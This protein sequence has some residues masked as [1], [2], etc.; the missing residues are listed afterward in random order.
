MGF[1][2]LKSLTSQNNEDTG[3]NM[4]ELVDLQDIINLDKNEINSKMDY[5]VETLV[6][7]FGDKLA[8]KGGYMLT[9]LMPNT[10]R[11][12][13][14]IDFSIGDSKLYH[15]LLKTMETIGNHFVDEGYISSYKIKDE[16][17]EFMSGGMDMYSS[18]G[19]KILGIDIG[20]HDISFGVTTT[21]ID[22]CELSAFM[23]ER[24][25]ADKITAILSRKRFRRPKDIYDLYCI[26]NCFDFNTS[27]INEF[28]LK[29]TQG[30][31]ADWNNFPFKE[32]IIVE[33]KKAYDKLI[34]TSMYKNV[35]LNKPDF[36]EVMKRFNTICEQLL[37]NKE[38][39][40]DYKKGV[41][42]DAL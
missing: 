28:I 36:Y 4:K 35:S 2:S 11:Q 22:I 12:T 38:S 33:Y 5:M 27:L 19:E 20:W 26:S 8:F 29:R 1:D 17:R 9:K 21:K 24:M 32:E 40:W 41:F 25:L 23:V 18:T 15:D 3:S 39:F 6:R 7:V 16:I 14:D 31:G 13:T 42:V 37:K 10:A 30:A 34:L